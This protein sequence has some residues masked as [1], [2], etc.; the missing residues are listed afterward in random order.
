MKFQQ[1]LFSRR[2]FL[3]CSSL[4]LGA[5]GLAGWRG[6][7]EPRKLS[8]NDRLN[9][10]VVGVA[11]QGK[12]HLEEC[13]KENVV[14][15]CDV[16]TQS[17]RSASQDFPRANPYTDFRRML[18]RENLDGVVIATP[19]H[20]HAVASVF[21][22]Q[23]GCHVFCADP[24]THCISEAR[25][26]ALAARR[27][28]RVTQMGGTLCDPALEDRV[29]DFVRGGAL[30]LVT[31]VHA[32]TDRSHGELNP[33]LA[34]SAAPPNVDYDLWLG[35]LFPRPYRNEFLPAR[36]RH[37]WLFGGGTLSDVGCCHVS[38]AH[39]ALGLSAPKRVQTWG[40]AL[41]L[42][43]TPGW[44]I[45]RSVYVQKDPL[46]EISLTWYH[47]GER[48][49]RFAE[50]VIRNCPEGLLFVGSAGKLLVEESRAQ[51]LVAGQPLQSLA[52]EPSAGNRRSRLCEWVE[53]CRSGGT[54]AGNFEFAA[55]VAESVLLA[56]VAYRTDRKLEWDSRRLEASNLPEA[57]EYVQHSYRPGWMI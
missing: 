37:W 23:Q 17:L 19:D 14:A 24:L 20:T 2:Q 32:W 57:S 44:L 16:D 33:G 31:E 39:R 53:A 12:L 10:G 9:L 49:T 56:N 55:S 34:P 45:A 43:Y 22:M 40:P 13:V 5:V 41:H 3:H 7:R 26:V 25:S 28:R 51:V 6:R 47:G 18:D 48:P 35:P 1:S 15:L 54:T 11:G 27:Y 50:P 46:P 36:W 4:A 38:L 21:A 30:G 42:D 52:V 29:V 8:A